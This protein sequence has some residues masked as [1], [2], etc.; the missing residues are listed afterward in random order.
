MI[1]S[2]ISVLSSATVAGEADTGGE[3]RMGSSVFNSGAETS[4]VGWVFAG[5]GEVGTVGPS[6]NLLS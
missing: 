5:L 2:G 1:G 6:P 3:S 4:G